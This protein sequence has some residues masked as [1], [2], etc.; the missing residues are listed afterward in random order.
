MNFL[1]AYICIF[2]F[3]CSSAYGVPASGIRYK[4]QLQPKPQQQQ[5]G[6][7]NPL[8]RAWDKMTSQHPQDAINPIVP[9]QEL[10]LFVLFKVLS[11]GVI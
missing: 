10:L 7:L 9:Q 8:C 2:F 11:T 3:G 4:P 1:F 6:I 5:C